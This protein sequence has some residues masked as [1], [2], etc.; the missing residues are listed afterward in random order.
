MKTQEVTKEDWDY[1]IILDACRY[2]DFEELHTKYLDGELEKK[3]SKGSSTLDWVVNNFNSHQ[4]DISYFSSNPYINSNGISLKETKWGSSCGYDWTATEHF[5]EIIDI[6]DSGWDKELGTVHPKKV[7]EEVLDKINEVNYKPIIHYMQPHAPFIS[8]GKSRKLRRI[9]KGIRNK[10]SSSKLMKKIR[11]KLET[12]LED[13][14]ISMKMGMLMNLGVSDL[15]SYLKNNG[16]EEK[17]RKYYRQNL[18]LALEHVS[19]LIEELEGKIIVTSDHGEAFGEQGIW[20][21]HVET[22]IPALTEVPWLEIKK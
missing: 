12:S 17:L 18:E 19:N 16:A 7:N 2:D 4:H 10:D 1:L 9:R 8:N 6:W 14:E 20:E 5:K 22:Y 15:L 11:S 3:E 13:K 21:H